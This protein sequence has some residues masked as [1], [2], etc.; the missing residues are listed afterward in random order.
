MFKR[1]IPRN[2]VSLATGLIT[3]MMTERAMK[4]ELWQIDR[5]LPY[6]K[7]PRKIPQSAVDKVAASIK[8]FGWQQPIVVDVVG[9]VVVGHTRLLAARKLGLLE[10]PVHVATDLTDAQ[11][12]AY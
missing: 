1:L 7:N 6:A 10:V 5:P 4:I 8:E 3:R 11:C 2:R 12:R 9:V